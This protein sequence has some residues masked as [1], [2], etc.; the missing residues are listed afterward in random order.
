LAGKYDYFKFE[1]GGKQSLVD[2]SYL[3]FT[4]S[5]LSGSVQLYAGDANNQFP[6]KTSYRL[7][8]DMIA[9]S[10]VIHLEPPNIVTGMYYLGVLSITDTSYLIT[11]SI[12]TR[13]YNFIGVN[14]V[15]FHSNSYWT[16]IYISNSSTTSPPVLL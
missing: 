6:T 13:K 7:A 8:G 16:N 3:D 1:F 11:A 2:N 12:S 9:T 10:S 15:R 14:I 5:P 4:V